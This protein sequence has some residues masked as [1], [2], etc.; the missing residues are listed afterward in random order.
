[1]FKMFGK[2]RKRTMGQQQR[3]RRTL[4]EQRKAIREKVLKA[5]RAREAEREKAGES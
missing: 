2:K 5:M 4:D 1:M 3:G